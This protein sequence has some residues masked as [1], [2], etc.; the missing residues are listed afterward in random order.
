MWIALTHVFSHVPLK[1]PS[2]PGEALVH[3]RLYFHLLSNEIRFTLRQ[4]VCWHRQLIAICT[5]IMQLSSRR[6]CAT[7]K[8]TTPSTQIPT[9]NIT[10]CR[11]CANF[12]ALRKCIRRADSWSTWAVLFELVQA[13]SSATRNKNYLV[14]FSTANDNASDKTLKV[15]SQRCKRMR[16]ANFFLWR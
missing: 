12:I 8:M 9:L 5:A 16:N 7:C 14:E 13:L 10:L 6:F 1:H 2:H 11:L 4:I 3:S 15:P